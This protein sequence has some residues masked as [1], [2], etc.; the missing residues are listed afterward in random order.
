M[1]VKIGNKVYSSQEGAIMVI[2]T[3]QDKDNIVA[4]PSECL[5]YCEY[6]RKGSEDADNAEKVY[7][8][9]EIDAWMDEV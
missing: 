3:Q 5:R 6:V 1:Q 4:M 8:R 2:F 9:E 7:T